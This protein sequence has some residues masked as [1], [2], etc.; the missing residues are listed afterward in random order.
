MSICKELDEAVQ[1]YLRT[2]T[3]PVAVKI[4]ENAEQ[5]PERTRR[6]LRDMGHRLNLCQGVAL[7]IDLK[8][9]LDESTL[10][11]R[12]LRDYAAMRGRTL[13]SAMDSTAAKVS[14]TGVAV[15]STG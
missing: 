13:R 1:K 7:A 15:Q 14:H 3:F 4:L 5:F 6:P 2:A 9:A 12:I 10:D 11:K 8:S